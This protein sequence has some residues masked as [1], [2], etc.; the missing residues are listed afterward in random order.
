MGPEIV[1]P[2]FEGHILALIWVYHLRGIWGDDIKKILA[3]HHHMTPFSGKPLA[4]T[5]IYYHKS[6]F[7]I[8]LKI[9]HIFLILAH[10]Y[11]LCVSPFQEKN[12]RGK[13]EFRCYCSSSMLCTK[14][15]THTEK[16]FSS[17][18]FLLKLCSTE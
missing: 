7:F 4:N 14:L 2:L 6:I 15:L 3:S 18:I 17:L 13:I 12:E 9:M 11:S 1:R 5:N 10:L 8:I 16:H